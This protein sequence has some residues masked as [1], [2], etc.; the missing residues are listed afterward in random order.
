MKKVLFLVACLTSSLSF[1][2]MTM[3][4]LDGTPI[5]NGDIL[6]YT[7]LGD[8]NNVSST[9]P[10]YLGFK[11]YNSSAANINVKMKLMS[12]TNATGSDLQFCIDPICVGTISVGSSYPSSGSSL[13]PANGQ[14]GNFDHFVNSHAGNGIDPVIYVLKFYMINGFGAEVGS[15]ITVTY[16]YDTTLSTPAFNDLKNKGIT[17]KSTLVDSQIEFEATTGGTSEVYDVNGRLIA[18]S[19]CTTGYN[20]INVSNLNTGVYI[21][22]FTTDEGKKASMKIIKK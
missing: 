6:T 20:N 13:V 1:S 18:N 4:K 22:S 8:S 3:K 14:N 21:V 16:K 7:V 15:S 12:M 2:Q 9:D 5:N 19:R 10:A 11:I 17:L